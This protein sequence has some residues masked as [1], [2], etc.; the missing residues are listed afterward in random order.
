MVIIPLPAKSNAADDTKIVLCILSP[1]DR[2][3]VDI[4]SPPR[5]N[6]PTWSSRIH[7]TS[8]YLSA[9]AGGR[10]GVL[11][12]LLYIKKGVTPK[13]PTAMPI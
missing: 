9:A 11:K 2:Q 5:Y 6:I 10:Y 1:L 12:G 8:V 4:S 7:T 13:C 3:V